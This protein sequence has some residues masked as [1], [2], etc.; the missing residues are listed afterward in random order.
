M[1]SSLMNICRGA[2]RQ[3]T[4]ATLACTVILLAPTLGRAEAAGAGDGGV[5]AFYAWKDAVPVPPG[6][7]LRSEPQEE[8]LALSGASRSV[9]LLYS[10][11]DGLD[12]HTPIAVSGALYLPK[13]ALPEG[14]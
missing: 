6:K 10:S 8:R 1:N 4:I 13:G 12:G 7:L 3:A 2:A 14:G 11:T 9:R 5:S